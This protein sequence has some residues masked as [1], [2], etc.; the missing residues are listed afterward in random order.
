MKRILILATALAGCAT[1]SGTPSSPPPAPA[2]ATCDAAAVQSLVGTPAA[3]IVDAQV[4]RQTGAALVRRYATGAMLT[5][6]YRADRL[7]VESDAA[8]TVVK[9]SCG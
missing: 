7:N 6:D 3:A 2:P 9:L 1:A 5:M 8:G 4:K